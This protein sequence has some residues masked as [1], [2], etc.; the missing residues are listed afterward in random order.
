MNFKNGN[1]VFFFLGINILISALIIF[2][3]TSNFY[4]KYIPFASVFLLIFNSYLLVQALKQ[5]FKKTEITRTEDLD[6]G[7]LSPAD[8]LTDIDVELERRRAAKKIERN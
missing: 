6:E 4:T 2:V 7:N 1:I 3:Y 8:I 5:R